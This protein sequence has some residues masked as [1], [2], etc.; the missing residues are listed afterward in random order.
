MAV[1]GGA[2]SVVLTALAVFVL[3]AGGLGWIGGGHNLSVSRWVRLFRT[4]CNTVWRL[5]NHIAVCSVSPDFRIF[6]LQFWKNCW[7]R[8][9]ELDFKEKLE[10]ISSNGECNQVKCPH[11]KFTFYLSL[12]EYGSKPLVLSPLKGSELWYLYANLWLISAIEIRVLGISSVQLISRI[13]QL[14]FRFRWHQRER[15]E[16]NKSVKGSQ[17]EGILVNSYAIKL[18]SKR[19]CL[20]FSGEILDSLITSCLFLLDK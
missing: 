17:L 13:L 9:T 15:H 16:Q 3:L 5:W 18:E 1:S 8:R 19:E 6:F 11:C 10:G 4:I 2:R 20:S 7:R 12:Y 14:P